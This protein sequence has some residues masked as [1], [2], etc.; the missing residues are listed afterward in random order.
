MRAEL[1]SNQSFSLRVEGLPAVLRSD[2]IT[3]EELA[4]GDRVNL[5]SIPDGKYF[6]SKADPGDDTAYTI[7]KITLAHIYF[8]D[9][10]TVKEK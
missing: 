8:D 2:L 9:E 6:A 5:F 4:S 3:Q 7:G 10:M 1:P